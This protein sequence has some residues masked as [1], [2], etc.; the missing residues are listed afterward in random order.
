MFIDN[1]TRYAEDSPLSGMAKRL[2]PKKKKRK[3][4]PS[5]DSNNIVL[6]K[7]RKDN[8]GKAPGIK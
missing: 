5:D 8:K 1:T 7:N 6:E 2:L 3:K 4:K